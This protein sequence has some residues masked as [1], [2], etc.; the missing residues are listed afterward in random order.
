MGNAAAD[1]I[2]AEADKRQ[3]DL[4]EEKKKAA[5][6]ED[7]KKK[8]KLDQDNEDEA[9]M[10]QGF[11]EAEAVARTAPNGREGAGIRAIIQ[12]ERDKL[13]KG[14]EADQAKARQQHNQ[15]EVDRLQRLIDLE[16]LR[17]L[18]KTKAGELLL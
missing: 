17:I 9:A 5:K 14:L 7:P 18:G 1:K 4:D 6:E 16:N 2:K 15:A 12:D 3:A 10:I 13:S 8:K 11:R